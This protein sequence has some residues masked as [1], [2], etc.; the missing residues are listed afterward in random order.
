MTKRGLV[1]KVEETRGRPLKS[2]KILLNPTNN[3]LTIIIRN[4]QHPSKKVLIFFFVT[5][6][7]AA[8]KLEDTL[9]LDYLSMLKGW[10]MAIS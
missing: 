8:S 6:E 7:T 4:N 5:F 1:R 2:Y 10:E 9:K 3:Q